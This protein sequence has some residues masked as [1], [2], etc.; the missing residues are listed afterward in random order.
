MVADN[1]TLGSDGVTVLQGNVAMRRTEG[2]LRANELR[3]DQGKQQVVAKDNV[4]FAAGELNL[5]SSEASVDLQA[6]V[7]QFRNAEFGV[8]SSNARGSAEQIDIAGD[9]T[10]DMRGVRY[11]TCPPGNE[12]WVLKADR[13]RLD[14]SSGQGKANNMSLYFKGVPI[15]YLPYMQFPFTDQRQSGLLAPSFGS[16]DSNGIEFGL[17]YYWNI[18]PNADATFTPLFLSRRG[19]RLDSEVRAVTGTP[20]SERLDQE[21]WQADTTVNMRWLP[22]DNIT[23]QQRYLADIDGGVKGQGKQHYWLWRT[24][25]IDVTDAQWFDDFGSSLADISQPF[26]VSRTTAEWQWGDNR[27][28][29]N[30]KAIAEDHEPLSGNTTSL[31]SRQ[32]ELYFSARQQVGK[33]PLAF[34]LKAQAGRFNQQD[35]STNITRNH[36]QP[37]VGLHFR[38]PGWWFETQA[39]FLS[40]RWTSQ[41]PGQADISQSRSLPLYTSELGLHLEKTYDKGHHVIEPVIG[42]R[43]APFR[44]QSTAP[45]LDTHTETLYWHNLNDDQFS[46]LDRVR[47]GQQLSAV[48]ASR[49]YN[50]EGEQRFGFRLGQLWY[51]DDSQVTLPGEA[52]V[53]DRSN[54]LFELIAAIGKRWSVST[55]GEWDSQ[56]AE[57]E[58]SQL[59]VDLKDPTVG[60]FYVSLRQRRDLFRQASFGAKRQISSHWHVDTSGLYSLDDNSFLEANVKLRYQTC[61]WAVD[62]GGRRVLRDASGEPDVGFF[63]QLELTGLA[64]IGSQ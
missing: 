54:T 40:T 19:W 58:H 5:V 11:T 15:L 53:G 39:N 59:R 7:A 29:L 60:D 17:P 30:L 6:N 22:D 32:P 44:D 46:G 42:F 35:S 63:I 31:I 24:Q 38:R 33:S 56:N 3:Y 50:L 64:Q 1:A 47:D 52:V 61:C 25:L 51:F 62:F 45:V 34:G 16:S 57:I 13:I 2:V 4:S 23:Q 10:P 14:Q 41:T 36:Y 12:S 20:L 55:A 28:H 18:A 26:F 37:W 43:A 21:W 8:A 27:D 9:G 49:W 48:L